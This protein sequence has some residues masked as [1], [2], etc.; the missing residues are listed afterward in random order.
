MLSIARLAEGATTKRRKAAN[1]V[2]AARSSASLWRPD[3]TVQS[4]LDAHFR[5]EIVMGKWPAIDPYRILVPCLR[6]CD[7]GATWY[8]EPD[9][10]MIGLYWWTLFRMP[11]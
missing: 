8:G 3:H 5:M 9:E 6:T 2:P 4:E 1:A 10:K 7:C 11:I